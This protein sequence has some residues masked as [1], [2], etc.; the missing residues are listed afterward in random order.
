MNCGENKP[1]YFQLFSDFS[2]IHGANI[3]PSASYHFIGVTIVRT[4][5]SIQIVVT[6]IPMVR[7]VQKLLNEI[8]IN[9]CAW[10]HQ[11]S[12]VSECD[13]RIS[14]HHF[15]FWTPS[16]L[17]HHWCWNK[18]TIPRPN[19]T[20]IGIAGQFIFWKFLPSQRSLQHGLSESMVWCDYVSDESSWRERIIFPERRKF[21]NTI[22][23]SGRFHC[24]KDNLRP[25]RS[26][27]NNDSSSSWPLKI[28]FQSRQR[29]ETWLTVVDAKPSL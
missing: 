25:S 11:T 29:A 1:I 17:L 20:V 14:L 8:V 6:A 13:S 27:G 9:P 12:V 3:G 5:I 22:A 16:S 2:K 21:M 18:M 7:T 26:G 10:R 15:L 19:P 28:M 23:R 24:Q 4:I